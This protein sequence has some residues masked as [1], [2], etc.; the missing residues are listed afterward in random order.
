MI[1]FE[2][3]SV[4][5][6]MKTKRFWAP[7]GNVPKF[8]SKWKLKILFR[9]KKR[10]FVFCFSKDMESLE[11]QKRLP[12][13]RQT[14]RI[15]QSN[16][17]ERGR[18]PGLCLQKKV[19]RTRNVTSIRKSFFLFRE[20]AAFYRFTKNVFSTVRRIYENRPL[21]VWTKRSI[22]LSNFFSWRFFYDRFVFVSK[23]RGPEIIDYERHRSVDSSSRRT[24][25]H[26]H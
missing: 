20:L 3:P 7:L 11:L 12:T 19:G 5:S 6:A 15:T 13:I 21:M 4:C 2:S 9:E 16:S 23:R 14:L 22:Y 25:Q 8:W 10:T 24:F 17:R 26:W 1:Y 18:L